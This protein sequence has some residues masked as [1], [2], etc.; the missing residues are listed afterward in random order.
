MGA[1]PAR[2][3]SLT[4][5]PLRKRRGLYGQ[6]RG[7]FLRLV[8]CGPTKPLCI[9]PWKGE[10]GLI[11]FPCGA[12][13]KVAVFG[14]ADWLVYG[15]FGEVLVAASEFGCASRFRVFVW[16]SGECGYFGVLCDVFEDVCHALHAFARCFDIEFG[17]FVV[18]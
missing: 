5:A 18:L 15:V 3:A 2:I 4:R 1:S 7:L 11:D 17:W 13:V 12:V 6:P 9:S 14:G 10:G 16:A 8:R